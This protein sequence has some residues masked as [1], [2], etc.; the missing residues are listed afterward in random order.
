[1][2]MCSL[3]SSFVSIKAHKLGGSHQRVKVDFKVRLMYE[4]HP[5]SSDNGLI[6]QKLLFKSESFYPLHVAMNV[7]YSCLKY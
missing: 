7:A 2:N 3:I 6:S 1:M 4:G 5:I